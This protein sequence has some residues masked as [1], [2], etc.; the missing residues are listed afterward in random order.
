MVYSS[1]FIF[2][3]GGQQVALESFLPILV[4]DYSKNC[5]GSFASLYFSTVF[6]TR[7]S[8]IFRI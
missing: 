6:E 5:C 3:I 4:P 1:I 7:P 8:Y 2:L